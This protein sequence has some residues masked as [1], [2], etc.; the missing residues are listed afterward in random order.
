MEGD[1]AGGCFAGE[2]QVALADGRALSFKDL[3]E[4]WRQGEQNFCYTVLPDGNIGI[5]PIA[6]PRKTRSRAAVVEVVLDNHERVVCTPAHLFMLR[7]GTYRRA[8]ALSP[9]DSLMPLYRQLS[10]RAGWMTIDGYELVFDPAQQRW[11]F[12]HALADEHNIRRGLYRGDEA[13]H[14]HHVDFNKR[15]NNPTNVRRLTKEQHLEEHRRHAAKTLHRRDVLEKLRRLRKTAAYRERVR[16][17]MLRPAMREA[18]RLRARRQW[19]DPAYKS[20]M[21]ERFLTF[22]RSSPEYRERSR[23]TLVE[24]QRTYWA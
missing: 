6:H 23:A 9:T 20:Y 14:R 4:E 19:E 5:E 13:S 2:T 8:D 18:L 1:S 22:Y 24:A 10:R 16:Q 11:V 12:T 15:N 21:T 3:T 7:D 17:A